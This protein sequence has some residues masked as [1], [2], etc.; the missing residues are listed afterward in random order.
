C[1]SCNTCTKACPQDIEVM[2]YVQSIIQGDISKA[3]NLS[4]DCLM[5]G[6]CALRCPAEIT[7]FQSA[8]LARRLFAKYIQPKAF[9]L[10]ERLKEIQNGKFEQEMKKILSTGID[11]LKKLY[12]RREI[13]PE[14][15]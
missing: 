3:A 9:H 2:D 7:Q 14:E 10:S 6:L 4:F 12:N 13:E 8:I 5:C 1:L 15:T 11:E